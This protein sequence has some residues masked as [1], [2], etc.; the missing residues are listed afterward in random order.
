MSQQFGTTYTPVVKLLGVNVG[1]TPLQQPV[2]YLLKFTTYLHQNA[3]T[4]VFLI[5]GGFFL[6][7]S[8]IDPFIEKYKKAKSHREATDPARVKI[9]GSD[10]RRIRAAQQEDNERRAV[11][12]IEAAKKK[13]REE[14]EKKR[15]KQPMEDKGGGGRRLNENN[16]SSTRPGYNPMDPSSGNTSQNRPTRRNVNTG[17][18]GG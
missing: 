14:A 11:E 3:W 12:A 9:L 6:K 16:A 10:M 5:A 8:V 18:G 7:N 13:K 2:E 15:I 1:G 17:R 4:V